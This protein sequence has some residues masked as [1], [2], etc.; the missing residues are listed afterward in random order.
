MRNM[1]S[2]LSQVRTAL[3]MIGILT[4]VNHGMF[5]DPRREKTCLRDFQPGPGC[6]I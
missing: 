5:S 2:L 4:P 6:T 3:T 1:T